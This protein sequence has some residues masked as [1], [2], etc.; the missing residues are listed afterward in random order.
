MNTRHLVV[1]LALA[2]M[3]SGAWAAPTVGDAT[4]VS[5][6]NFTVPVSGAAG[7]TY[8]I[9]GQATGTQNWMSSNSSLSGGAADV[10][11]WG[12]PLIGG[13]TVYY[14]ACDSTGCSSEKTV[15][16]PTVT[17][18]PVPTY[19]DQLRRISDSHF[20]LPNIT[21]E[22]PVALTSAL[23]WPILLIFGIIYVAIFAGLWLRVRTVRMPL[24][25]AFIA[26]PFVLNAGAGLYLGLPIDLGILMTG[27][28]AAA[29]AG[30]VYSFWN[31]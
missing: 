21:A 26:I 11:V 8:V 12:A 5:S 31:S 25:V 17:P 20:G 10:R 27:L 24:M 15:A 30:T 28:M 16:I 7:Y 19:G 29:L 2:L 4:L 23:G 9:W 3:V 18:L 6:N 14:K 13:R 1:L 22:I